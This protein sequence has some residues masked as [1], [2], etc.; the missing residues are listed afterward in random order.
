MKIN[1]QTEVFHT[2]RTS[3]KKWK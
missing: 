1:T 2:I 3:S